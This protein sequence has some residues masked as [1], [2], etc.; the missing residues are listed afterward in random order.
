MSVRTML[1][2]AAV[3]GTVVVSGGCAEAAAQVPARPVGTLPRVAI[4]DASPQI[5][6]TYSR[7]IC[8]GCRWSSRPGP[9]ALFIVDGVALPW[10]L[11]P[12]ARGALAELAARDIV[13]IY[14]LKSPTLAALLGRHA[15]SGVVLI[16]TRRGAQ[17][18]E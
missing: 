13:S 14:I 8:L 18:R 12:G 7:V 16:T 11:R 15:A 2:W 9:P 17:P 6:T 1:R 10:K 5:T 4:H 3:A